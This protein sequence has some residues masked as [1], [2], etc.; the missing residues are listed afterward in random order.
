MT[1]DEQGKVMDETGDVVGFFVSSIVAK[2]AVACMTALAHVTDKQLES[3]E[4]LHTGLAIKDLLAAL[5]RIL[6]SYR[7][8]KPVGYP[9]SDAEKI[10]ES[11]IACAKSTNQKLDGEINPEDIRTETYAKNNGGFV[12]A[13]DSGI[14]LF[15]TPTG[16]SA[17][18][19]DERSQHRNRA[20]AFERLTE[21]LN[22]MKGGA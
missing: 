21:A 10:A 3:G 4:V 6:R 13:P 18:C 14:R 7:V 16:I 1:S 22:K 8:L 15:H 17:E 20:V 12:M 11:A 9:L 5:E 2:R 19:N